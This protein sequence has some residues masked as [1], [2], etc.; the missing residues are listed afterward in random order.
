V[1]DKPDIPP[2]TG[3]R[4]IA[5]LLVV[6]NHYPALAIPDASKDLLAGVLWI[7]STGGLAMTLFFTL[8]GFI[9]TYN[10]FSLGWQVR[11]GAS[12]ATFMWLRVTRLYPALLIFLVLSAIANDLTS[13]DHPI[14]W[15]ALHVLSVETW[16]PVFAHGTIPSGAIFGVGWSVSTEIGMYAMFACA[17]MLRGRL[18]ASGL[19]ALAVLYLFAILY[20]S[21]K[22]ASPG[23]GEHPVAVLGEA[24]PHVWSL[25]FFYCS[26]YFRFLQFCLGA[27]T[28]LA[29]IRLGTFRGGRMLAAASMV[30]LAVLALAREGEVHFAGMFP[31]KL[32]P[33]YDLFEAVLIALFI[34]NCADR[35]S[36]LNRVLGIPAL[37]A[38]GTVSYSLYLFH[39]FVLRLGMWPLTALGTSGAPAMAALAVDLIAMLLLAVSLAYSM[40]YLIE[41]PAKRWLRS[42]ARSFALPGQ[43]PSGAAAIEHGNRFG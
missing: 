24:S 16:L 39:P 27:G 1:S 31:L 2:L 33:L 23:A 11:P 40:H 9:I 18:R 21:A 29:F 35:A 28:A 43:A 37:T 6:C 3:L 13:L 34:L 5:A 15:T 14:L 7:F 38:I 42:M 10:Y 19:I 22:F 36:R 26:P 20:F 25:W 8:S 32:D 17:M 30:V 12:F 4:G 41:L